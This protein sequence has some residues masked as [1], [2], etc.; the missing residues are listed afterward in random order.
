MWHQVYHIPFRNTS[1][2]D[3]GKVVYVVVIYVTALTRKRN[4]VVFSRLNCDKCTPEYIEF[5]F[6]ICTWS[7]LW[8]PHYD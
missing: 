7:Y 4:N 3:K 5:K 6:L 2:K 1:R 8:A